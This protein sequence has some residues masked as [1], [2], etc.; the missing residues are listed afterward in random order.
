MQFTKLFFTAATVVAL[1][2]APNVYAA[3]P[4]NEEIKEYQEYKQDLL[5]RYDSYLEQRKKSVIG[6]SSLFDQKDSRFKVA[7]SFP[8]DFTPWWRNEAGEQLNSSAYPVQVDVSSLF[9]RAINNSSQVKSFSDLPLIRRTT[10]QEADGAYDF[11][12]FADG[13]YNDLDEPVGDDLT[14]GGPERYEESGKELKYGVRKKFLTGTEVELHQTIGDLDTNSI[15]FNPEDQALSGTHLIVRQ[16]LL[17]GFGLAYNESAINLAKIDHDV[18]QDEFRRNLESHLLEVA[19]SYW[20]LYLERTLLLQ[21]RELAENTTDYLEQLKKRAS[22]DGSPSILARAE[23]MVSSHVLQAMQAEYAMQNAQSRILA[24]LNDHS[25]ENAAGIEMISYQRPSNIL[26]T[27]SFDEVIQTTLNNRPEIDQSVRQLKAAVI[28][29][30]RSENELRPDLNLYFETYVEGLE[31]DYEYGTAYSNQF[32]EGGPSYR[33]GLQFE[34]P[35]GNN[36]AK[37]RNTRKKLEIRQLTRQLDITVENVVL[38]AEISHREMIKE[39]R[40]MAQSFNIMKAAQEEQKA[41]GEKID[42]HLNEN[43]DYGELL[44]RLMDARERLTKAEEEF[45]MSELTYNLALY[46]LYRTMGVLVAK[47][48]IGV[49]EHE[50][51]EGLPELKVVSNET[52]K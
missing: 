12:I 9:I 3:E 45:A 40:S 31:G 37:A 21:K 24:L 46:N 34:F 25:L 29:Y 10:I 4:G 30:D 27:I 18:A 16:P 19:R 44:Y 41:L 38:E 49:E 13:S 39:Y 42:F 1:A 5:K 6:Y 52:A 2:T 7:S 47:N 28:R 22:L 26:P 50:D 35:L 20:G 51:D 23:A 33:V 8:A 48:N 11:R 43:D 15:Y 36:S 17:K 14:T 32:D